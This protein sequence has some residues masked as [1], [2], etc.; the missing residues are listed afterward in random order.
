[1][2]IYRSCKSDKYA[3]ITPRRY[4]NE[5]IWCTN[6]IIRNQL[7]ANKFNYFRRLALYQIDVEHY[8]LDCCPSNFGNE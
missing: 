7:L 8:A 6:R 2:L 4:H 5:I 3:V 1:M